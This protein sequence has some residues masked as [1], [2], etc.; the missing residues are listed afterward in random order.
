MVMSTFI[1]RGGTVVHSSS[2][3][4]ADVLI[5]DGRIVEVGV[6]L[7][8]TSATEI[9]AD[10]CLVGPAFVDLHT[11]LREPGNEAAETIESGAR[12]AAVG[13]YGAVVAMPKRIANTEIYTRHSVRRM[14][15][16]RRARER[17]RGSFI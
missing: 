4:R 16:W 2:T 15:A 11:H 7:D 17:W 9:D 6:G 1:I 12:A 13:G 10:G 5:R 8:A 14:P 3:Q